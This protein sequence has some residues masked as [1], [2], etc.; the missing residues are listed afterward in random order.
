MRRRSA[1]RTFGTV[2]AVAAVLVVLTGGLVAAC[3]VGA[4]RAGGSPSA[5]ASAGGIASP[6]A[7]YATPT[8]SGSP[9]PDASPDAQVRYELRARVLRQAGMPGQTGVSCD[10]RIDGHSDQ[11]VRCVVG[12]DELKVPFTVTV[13]GGSMLFS[14]QASQSQTVL[15]ADGVTAAFA[16]HAYNVDTS[17]DPPAAGSVRCGRLPARELV[18]FDRPTPYTCSLRTTAGT[19]TSTVSVGADGPRFS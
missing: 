9:G 11:T 15:T 16:R 5:S 8:P 14:F 4:A 2:G 1:M 13:T 19:V 18:G 12:Y 7:S 3:G 10:T 6:T 17:D